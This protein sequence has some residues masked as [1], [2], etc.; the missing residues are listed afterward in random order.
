MA[1]KLNDSIP[2]TSKELGRDFF[3]SSVILVE[4]MV[5]LKVD[6]NKLPEC[7][8]NRR[9]LDR[10]VDYLYD[11]FDLDNSQPVVSATEKSNE[12]NNNNDNKVEI[13][14]DNNVSDKLEK[15]PRKNLLPFAVSACTF[16]LL[17]F[18]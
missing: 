7:A 4:D 13:K 6:G 1:S 15:K 16:R 9:C 14:S 12:S 10:I 2:R 17:P 5:Y 18:G 3:P 11:K 8:Q